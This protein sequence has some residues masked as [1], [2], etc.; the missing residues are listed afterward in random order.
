MHAYRQFCC[1]SSPLEPGEVIAAYRKALAA[2]IAAYRPSITPSTFRL[3]LEGTPVRGRSAD[4]ILASAANNPCGIEMERQ[5]APLFGETRAKRPELHELF[6]ANYRHYRKE[7]AK[8][9]FRALLKCHR[10]AILVDIPHLLAAGVGA[11]EDQS[12]LMRDTLEA[13]A[14][15]QA[16]V[17]KLGRAAN[18]VAGW[19]I[20][21][22]GGLRF[23]FGRVQRVAFVATKS[24]LVSPSDVHN[25]DNLLKELTIP[26]RSHLQRITPEQIVLAAVKSTQPSSKASTDEMAWLYGRPQSEATNPPT[27][28]DPQAEK[29]DY[30]VSRI[31][32]EWPAAW[33]ANQYSFPPVYPDIPRARAAVPRMDNLDQ[34]FRFIVE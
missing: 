6:E 7:V 5:F 22:A 25:L 26:L 11:D 31:P 16:I 17:H 4:D 12:H 24:D 9:L 32:A 34:L 23:R 27:R 18:Y 19:T 30:R 10:L 1:E 14:P 20:S 8:P 3:S 21:L 29:V 28:R 33:E 2:L 15:K 13:L